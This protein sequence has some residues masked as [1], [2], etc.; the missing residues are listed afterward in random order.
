MSLSSFDTDGQGD[1][2]IAHLHYFSGGGDWY[3]TEKDREGE[4]EQAFGYAILHGD[5]INAEYG[6]IPIT[7]LVDTGVG[8]ELDFHF[9]PTPMA[10]IK[11]ALETAL[12]LDPDLADVVLHL[13]ESQD[14]YIH[15]GR[16]YFGWALYLLS[17]VEV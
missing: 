6:Y 5:L 11:Q 10:Q 15:Y 7:E 14:E 13:H 1:Q 17:P 3:I 8:A 12:A 9:K 4:V 2:A 16:E